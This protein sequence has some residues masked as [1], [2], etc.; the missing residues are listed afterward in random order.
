MNAVNR[1]RSGRLVRRVVTRSRIWVSGNRRGGAWW[2]MLFVE[3]WGLGIQ[4]LWP[5][6]RSREARAWPGRW[7]NRRRGRL[8]N[9]SPYGP[10]SWR[11]MGLGCGSLSRVSW[12]SLA[13]SW[14]RIA[15][16]LRMERRLRLRGGVRGGIGKQRLLSVRHLSANRVRRRPCVRGLQRRRNLRTLMRRNKDLL[17]RQRPGGLPLQRNRTRLLW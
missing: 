5:L 12:S 7:G 13:R 11:C 17:R 3:G 16:I 9:A 1:S 4:G 6:G 15:R 2:H 14:V 10:V 8:G